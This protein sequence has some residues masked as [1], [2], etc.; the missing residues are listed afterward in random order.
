ML[1]FLLSITDE[2]KKDALKKIFSSCH[3]DMLRIARHRLRSLENFE[4]VAEDTVE[5]AF[6]K[7]IKYTK[8]LP[9]NNDELRAYAITVTVNECT[10]MLNSFEETLCLRDDFPDKSFDED[11]FIESLH[12]QQRYEDAVKG[13]KLLPD[14]YRS[15][16]YMKHVLELTP[17][18]ISEQTGT[19]I[20]T[21]YTRLSR[22]KLMLKEYLE[23][24]WKE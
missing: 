23:R 10:N 20:K 12:L 3:D 19:P 7:I 16:I 22:G 17:E 8:N 11:I 24:K 14:K 21:V 15:I 4:Y 9:N 18:E 5:N 2:Y 13:I 6:L 1:G